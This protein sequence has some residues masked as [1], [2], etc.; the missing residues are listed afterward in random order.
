VGFGGH[1][2]YKIRVPARVLLA[3]NYGQ[4]SEGCLSGLSML[5]SLHLLL[6]SMCNNPDTMDMSSLDHA[7]LAGADPLGAITFVENHDSDRGGIGGPIVRNKM[8]AY[9][10]TLTSEGYLCVF[11]RNHSMDKNCFGVKKPIDRLIWIQE[12]L[13]N[14]GTQQ[15]W[16]DNGAFAFERHGTSGAPRH[17]LV[18]LNKDSNNVRTISVQTGFFSYTQLQDFA[19]HAGPITTDASGNVPLTIPK[20]TNGLGYVCYS[21]PVPIAEFNA[22]PVVTTQDY[23]A[24]DLDI[25]GATDGAQIRVC[26]V[27]A[28]ANTTI[29]GKSSLARRTGRTTRSS[30]PRFWAPPAESSRGST[31][32]GR[33][34]ERRS[35]SRPAAKAFLH[36]C[37]SRRTRRALKLRPRIRSV[38]PAQ[39]LKTQVQ[40]NLP[41]C[42]GGARWPRRL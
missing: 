25:A 21:Q 15:H 7:G 40:T 24:H 41:S 38:S 42:N 8:L 10:C 4:V 37:C 28:G 11:Y 14:G 39:P 35:P 19:G 16:K 22:N 36:S 9:A 30:N 13:A 23:G 17:L 34:P 3:T 32:T 20:C 12:H 27:Y 5:D 1:R 33:C 6:K 2:E 29:E 26:R 18:G 31:L